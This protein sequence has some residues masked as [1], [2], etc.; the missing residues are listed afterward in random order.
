MSRNSDGP[1]RLLLAKVVDDLLVAGSPAE[2]AALKKKR[3]RRFK[4]GSLIRGR[5][6]IFN[7]HTIHQAADFSVAVNMDEFLDKIMP[8]PI[9]CNCRKSP[10][11]PAT[12]AELSSFLGLT[13]PLNFLGHGV[14]PHASFAAS[15][16]QQLVGDLR[17]SHLLTANKVLAEIKGLRPK[18]QY[19]TPTCRSDSSYLAFSDASTG[20]RSYVQTGFASDLYLP[21]GGRQVYH[22][23]NWHSSKQTRVSFSSTRA[24]ILAAAT[25]AD[26]GALMAEG[27]SRILNKGVEIPFVLTVDSN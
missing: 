5:E 16:L 1:I 11:T 9:P 7:R 4:V 24:E 25:S 26:R 13:S 27:L 3:A 22:A 2:L 15:R 18:F 20:K 19:L 14:L 10:G 6:L 12:P 8:L 21:D 17:V 23:I